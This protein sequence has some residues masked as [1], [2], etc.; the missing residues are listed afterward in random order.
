MAKTRLVVPPWYP[1]AV[2]AV[3]QLGDLGELRPQSWDNQ[4]GTLLQYCNTRARLARAGGSWNMCN[5][6]IFCNI[7][8]IW[9]ARA[10]LDQ[11]RLDLKYCSLL[12]LTGLGWPDALAWIKSWFFCKKSEINEH[13]VW[14]AC[15]PC[16]RQWDWQFLD[17]L[18]SKFKTFAIACLT[19]LSTALVSSKRFG[20]SQ[21]LLLKW[22]TDI[23]LPFKL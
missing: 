1:A 4:V 12:G 23:H 15:L 22:L 3:Q 8:N 17:L 10:E 7:C 5:I 14:L 2:T 13:F 18:C 21:L 6:C 16:V 20:N 19:C 9:N 11:S